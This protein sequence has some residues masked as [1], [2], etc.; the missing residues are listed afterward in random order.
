M[1]EQVFQDRIFFMAENYIA[2][3]HVIATK[4]NG[5]YKIDCKNFIGLSERFNPVL[6]LSKVALTFVS[7]FQSSIRS[8]IFNVSPALFDKPDKG[9]VKCKVVEKGQMM[10]L[11]M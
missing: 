11:V 6:V 10:F 9:Y 5:E 1:T 8:M 7:L 4:D 2:S 3:C